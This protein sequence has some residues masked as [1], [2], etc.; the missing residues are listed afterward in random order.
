M[1]EMDPILPP[2]LNAALTQFYTEPQ[3]DAVFAARLGAQLRQRQM[4]M[5][6]D[7]PKTALSL[8]D[9]SANVGARGNCQEQ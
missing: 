8:D 2:S 3:P 4:E 9:L 6:G 1:S 5:H 7:R